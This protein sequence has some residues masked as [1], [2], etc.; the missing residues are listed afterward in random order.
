M[1]VAAVGE[2]GRTKKFVYPVDNLSTGHEQEYKYMEQELE[3]VHKKREKIV[4][5]R[6]RV[7]LWGN[8]R[9]EWLA[10]ETPSM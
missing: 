6:E 4:G 3:R 8:C 9:D 2:L 1:E 5:A 7:S 10:A